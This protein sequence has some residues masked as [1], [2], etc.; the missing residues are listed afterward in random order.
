MN[1]VSYNI[2]DGGVGR[3]DPIAE[4]IAAHRP[5]VVVLVEADDAAVIERIARRLN[6]DVAAGRGARH[7]IALMSSWEIRE[8]IDF[9][10]IDQSFAGCFLEAT[11]RAPSGS[12]MVV[13]G[14]H[15]HARARE[16]DERRRE[17]Q[18]DAILSRLERHRRSSRA[19]II[20]GDLNAN[21]PVQKI[22]PD[23]CKPRTREDWAANGG[24]IPRRAIARLL[25]AGYID[26]L[27]HCDPQLASTLGSFTTRN[28]G[29]RVDYVLAHSIEP[30]RISQAWIERDRLAQ[31]AS[32]H[33]PV[34]VRIEW[35]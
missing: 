20:C 28:P 34:G 29:Q 21:S 33:Y 13:A 32:D 25:A 11:I 18:V 22:D 6:M 24:M 31:F 23:Q 12:D 14:V 3:A 5:N 2:L 8:S 35:E 10:R 19:H 9:G 15:L 27:Y 7:G 16:Q 30:G 17:E 4:V 1:L 26:T